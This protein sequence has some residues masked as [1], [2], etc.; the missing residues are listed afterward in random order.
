MSIVGHEDSCTVTHTD[1]RDSRTR[2][3]APCLSRRPAMNG[4]NMYGLDSRLQSKMRTTSCMCSLFPPHVAGLWPWHYFWG[5]GPVGPD[6]DA[7]IAFPIGLKAYGFLFCCR[8]ALLWGTGPESEC[9]CALLRGNVGKVCK[10]E[11]VIGA[12]ACAHFRVG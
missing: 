4:Q 2:T 5:G 7:R 3:N 9:N 1:I 6:L 8:P 12:C 11:G 10:D